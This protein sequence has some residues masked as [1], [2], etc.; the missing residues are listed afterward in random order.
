MIVRVSMILELSGR[1][2]KE[3]V[4]LSLL[5]SSDLTSSCLPQLVV[6]ARLHELSDLI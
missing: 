6:L 3:L 4:D 1:N 5:G 2:L